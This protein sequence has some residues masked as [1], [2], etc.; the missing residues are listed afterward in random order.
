MRCIEF[1]LP[2]KILPNAR[3]KVC[4]SPRKNFR[5]SR[6]TSSF[7]ASIGDS[8]HSKNENSVSKGQFEEVLQRFQKESIGERILGAIANSTAAPMGTY[9]SEPYT[10]LHR[11]D[12]R[13]KQASDCFFSRSP[14]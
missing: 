13:V 10:F 14:I 6:S 9:N 5:L 2:L 4:G 8:K 1:L 11:L 3:C 7:A 12:P